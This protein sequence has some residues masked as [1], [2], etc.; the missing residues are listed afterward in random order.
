MSRTV[1]YEN[2]LICDNCGETGAFDFMGDYYC[3]DCLK[4]CENC[5]A[6]FLIDTE[7]PKEEQKFCSDCS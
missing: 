3:G 4:S 5:D 7:K 6:I 1:P 2:H